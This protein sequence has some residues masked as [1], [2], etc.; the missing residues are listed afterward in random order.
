MKRKQVAV[1]IAFQQTK[2]RGN[3][4]VPVETIKWREQQRVLMRELNGRFAGKP[5][6]LRPDIPA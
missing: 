4:T 3:L 2:R 6:P 1:A 5:F